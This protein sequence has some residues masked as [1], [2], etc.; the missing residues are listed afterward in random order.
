MVCKMSSITAAL[1]LAMTP[2]VSVR[3]AA[4]SAPQ[5]ELIFAA[6][7]AAT[8]G[9]HWDAV[10]ELD[11]Q[12]DI[13]QGGQK[14][15]CVQ[16]QDLLEGRSMSSCT[17][18]G[19][20]DGQGYDGIISWFM[21]EK[22]M[23]SARESIQ[24]KREAVTDAYIAR[25]GWFRSA[26]ADPATMHFVGER[27]EVGRNFDVVHVVPKGGMAFDAWIDTHSH[28]LNR[29]AEDTDDGET[30]TTWYTDYR[31]VD[32]VLV[33][34]AQRVGNG[35]AQYDM[36]SHAQQIVARAI[37][38]DA[39]FAMPSSTVRDAHI[40]GGASSATVPFVPYGGLIMVEVSIDGAKPLPFI[41][42]TG[43]LNLL[44]PDAA[45]KL[46]VAGEGNQ[47]VRGVGE[48]TQSMQI[49]Q[50][51][52]YRVGDVTMDDQRF[53]IVDLPRLLTDRGEHEPIAGLIGYEL[54]RRFATRIDYDKSVL[55]FTPEALFHGAPRATSIPI[56]FNDRTPQVEARVNDVPGTFSLDTGDAG[57]L[58]VFAPFAKAH[59]IEPRGKT[60]AS[61]A[62][63]AGGA[64]GMIEAAVD[65]FSIGSFTLTHPTTSFAAPTKG[66]FA[67]NLLAGNIGY[68]VLSRF[69]VTF[70]YERR[71]LYLQPGDHFAVALPR[72]R[73]GVGLDRLSHDAFYVA[74]LVPHSPGDE[75]G[76]HVGDLVTAIDQVPV[77]RMGLDD[78]RRLMQQS[79]GTRMQMSIMRN[80]AASL[81]TLTL[82][83]L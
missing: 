3:A 72:G 5:P 77:A 75:A 51:K 39:R 37:P 47:A 69:I 43:G 68:G 44:T 24:A 80:S 32:G 29:V 52:S 41:L 38:D 2:L 35:D 16:Y 74:T 82:R 62:R 25:N 54:L 83:D 73:T 18:G 71:Q 56:V 40:D 70:D 67:S 9:T 22:S 36:T 10:A 50:I 14:G 13:E 17:L 63:G 78:V 34:Y 7:K 6:M 58:T 26:S 64:I 49:A 15:H 45:H 30:Q 81:R 12:S 23:V 65:T 76:L 55:T 46:G 59:A 21:D 8:G 79:A 1:A 20:Q 19:V 31:S 33:P 4:T 60:Y 53:M 28:L 42:D 57:N 27:H 11:Q 66:G 61:Q 48:A